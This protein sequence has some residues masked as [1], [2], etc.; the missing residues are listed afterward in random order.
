M[1]HVHQPGQ[2]IW[3]SSQK[4]DAGNG[5]QFANRRSRYYLTFMLRDYACRLRKA[6]QNGKSPEE[7]RKTKTGYLDEVYR[8]LAVHL[9]EPPT[10]F[11]W[12]WR[13]KDKKFP[14]RGQDHS[15]R[16]LYKVREPEP[17]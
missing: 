10:E 5:K 13:D 1:A 12:Q 4:G 11:N 6:H 8:I 15:N 16:V 14:P 3:R 2:Q 9:G 7:L 17:G